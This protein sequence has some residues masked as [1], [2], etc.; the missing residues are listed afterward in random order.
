MRGAILPD[1]LRAMCCVESVSRM[2]PDIALAR[3]GV[4]RR[5][6]LSAESDSEMRFFYGNN[7]SD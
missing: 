1:P 3:C 2:P 5:A 7:I 6:W 4:W